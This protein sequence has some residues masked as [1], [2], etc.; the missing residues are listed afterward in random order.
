M[1]LWSSEIPVQLQLSI[2]QVSILAE[3]FLG[4]LGSQ[5]STG[6]EEF[7]PGQKRTEVGSLTEFSSEIG[8]TK[9]HVHTQN[10]TETIF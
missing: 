10:S 4:S 7:W 9:R 1:A 8:L 6:T 5:H 3:K 2:R